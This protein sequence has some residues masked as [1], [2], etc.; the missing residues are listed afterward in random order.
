M[1]RE[2]PWGWK[3]SLYVTVEIQMS[4]CGNKGCR[5]QK[6]VQYTAGCSLQCAHDGKCCICPRCERW[7]LG[8][9]RMTTMCTK[10]PKIKKASLDGKAH[11]PTTNN[12]RIAYA[13]PG[14]R[15]HSQPSCAC[16][17]T[18]RIHWWMKTKQNSN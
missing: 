4:I 12:S 14:S 1:L 8:C 18:Q 17:N 9:P 11:N 10:K 7:K 13:F 15:H 3:S 6:C 5:W 16:T 2:Q